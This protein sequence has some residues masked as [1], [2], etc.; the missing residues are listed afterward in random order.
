[1]ADQPSSLSE[2][3]PGFDPQ[4]QQKV[5]LLKTIRG[6]EIIIKGKQDL[7]SKEGSAIFWT[8]YWW[9]KGHI[10]FCETSVFTLKMTNFK[11]RS[12]QRKLHVFMQ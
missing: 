4:C 3:Y 10:L 5:Y 8:K 11:A 7:D 9:G 6:I 12:D 1:M 2:C